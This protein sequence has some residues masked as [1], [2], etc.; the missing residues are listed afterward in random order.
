MRIFQRIKEWS[1]SRGISKQ[2]VGGCDWVFVVARLSTTY[3]MFKISGVKGYTLHVIEELIEYAEAMRDGD[4]N[5]AV[6]AIADGGIFGSTEL[7][8]MGYDIELVT[9]EVLKVIE[10]RTGKWDDDVGK[11]IKDDSPQYIPDY[12]KNCKALV[13]K[14]QSLFGFGK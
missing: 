13:D 10:S 6:D 12:I 7:V 4:E 1:D 11:F 9:N 14:T 5:G 2:E 8:K 3:D